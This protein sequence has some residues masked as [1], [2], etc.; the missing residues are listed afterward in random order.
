MSDRPVHI[1]AQGIGA[2]FVIWSELADD[3]TGYTCEAQVRRMPGGLNSRSPL[4]AV[5]LEP[6]VTAFAG[7]STRGDGFNVAIDDAESA[8]LKPGIYQVDA[9]ISYSA[10]VVDRLTW[11]LQVTS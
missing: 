11:L 10:S 6:A 4:A 2:V 7:D 1:M 3:I 5:V 8:D 9:D